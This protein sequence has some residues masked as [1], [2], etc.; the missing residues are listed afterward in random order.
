MYTA[1]AL[2]DS[3]HTVIAGARS[4]TAGKAEGVHHLPLD[5]TND[6]SAA[7]FCRA[8]LEIAPRVDALVQCAGV[9]VLGSCEETSLDEYRHVMETDFLGMVRMNQLVLPMMRELRGGRIVLFSSINGLL[10][11]P[12]QSAYTAA[13]HAMEGYAECL[14]METRRFGIQVCLVEPGDHRG[15]S[16]VY[17]RHAAAMTETSPYAADFVSAA[18][19]I[20]RDEHGGCDPVKLGRTVARA[21]AR[22]RMPFR[23]RVAKTDQHLAVVLHDLLPSGL[24][25]AVLRGYYLGRNAKMR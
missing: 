7:A 8:A 6:E 2:R 23:L 9:L 11:V 10:G 5:V 20:R 13:K 15:G 25:S 24:F 19:T 22:R 3:G 4:F 14:A 21:L 18:E 12:Y 17:R 1:Q 16:D